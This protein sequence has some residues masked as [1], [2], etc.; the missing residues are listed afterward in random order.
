MFFFFLKK[1]I[2]SCKLRLQLFFIIIRRKTTDKMYIFS[3]INYNGQ[4]SYKF[5]KNFIFQTDTYI[6][7]NNIKQEHAVN[8]RTRIKNCAIPF[9][10]HWSAR[11]DARCK[12]S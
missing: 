4:N 11:R 2:I 7:Q 5:I 10:K 9:K 8:V 3:N 12:R 1:D 6:N